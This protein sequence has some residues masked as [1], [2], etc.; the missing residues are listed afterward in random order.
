MGQFMKQRAKSATSVKINNPRIIT[1]IT[2]E[3]KEYL[4]SIIRPKLK[5]NRLERELGILYM[6]GK[7]K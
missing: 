5:Q 6:M 1:P 3:N 2:E 4:N 7:I